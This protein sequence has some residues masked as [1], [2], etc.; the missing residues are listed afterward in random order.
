MLNIRKIVRKTLWDYYD[1]ITVKASAMC[2]KRIKKT[3]NLVAVYFKNYNY[4]KQP[5][6]M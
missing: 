2:D 4:C 6:F 5:I 3:E 1:Y